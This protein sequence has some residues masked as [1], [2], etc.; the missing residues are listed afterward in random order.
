MKGTAPPARD[1]GSFL[2]RQTLI[3]CL[4]FIISFSQ[5]AFKEKVHMH[6]PE[7]LESHYKRKGLCIMEIIITDEVQF[8]DD[9]SNIAFAHDPRGPHTQHN[10]FMLTSGLEQSLR[11][12]HSPQ[13]IDL[14]KKYFPNVDHEYHNRL[15]ELFY[16][17]L[18]KQM[19]I[20][21][22]LQKE[23]C[24]THEAL[25]RLSRDSINEVVN[26]LFSEVKHGNQHEKLLAISEHG[27][28]AGAQVMLDFFNE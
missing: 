7:L 11:K 25:F 1:Y 8:D 22:K 28:A 26:Y 6:K 3:G 14:L 16:L 20:I 24:L 19:G 9:G 4:N 2:K 15:E 21:L 27:S 23:D 10:I 18:F 13:L 12:K 17:C 5:T